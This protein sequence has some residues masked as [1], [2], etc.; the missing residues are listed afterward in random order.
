MS[1]RDKF[2][3]NFNGAGEEIPWDDEIE[4]GEEGW[5]PAFYM[6]KCD[7][8]EREVMHSEDTGE[9]LLNES[10]GDMSCE[11][12]SSARNGGDP[13]PLNFDDQGC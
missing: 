11:I 3:A 12:L 4:E 8:C 6:V 2:G 10:C 9:P 7:V 1:N 5:S 13:E